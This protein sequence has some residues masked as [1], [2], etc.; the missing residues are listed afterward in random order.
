MTVIHPLD[1]HHH[2]LL[3]NI[4]Y[5]HVLSSFTLPT[6]NTLADCLIHASRLATDP[7]S[8]TI[9]MLQKVSMNFSTTLRG[10]E[11]MVAKIFSVFQ[12]G[13]LAF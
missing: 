5:F 13:F 6:C 11:G 4:G 8:G 10:N 7:R 12:G 9:A 1:Y 3:I 2:L